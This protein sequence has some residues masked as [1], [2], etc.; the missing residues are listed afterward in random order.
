MLNV[1]GLKN[2]IVMGSL[3]QYMYDEEL[4]VL[5]VTEPHLSII[6]QERV[7]QR[8]SEFDVFI[9]IRKR[10]R[11]KQYQERRNYVHCKKRH[12]ETRKTMQV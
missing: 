6:N 10:K 2:E 8:F 11:N 12:R 3:K 5:F 4:E 1:N 9:R 7:K